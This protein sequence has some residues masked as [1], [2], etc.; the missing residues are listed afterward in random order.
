MSCSL[1]SY[2]NLLKP[3]TH[4]T[5]ATGQEALFA[6]Q[7]IVEGEGAR[8]SQRHDCHPPR[9]R[10]ITVNMHLV[11]RALGI[12]PATGHPL[13]LGAKS[14]DLRLSDNAFARRLAT[15][16]RE[17]LLRAGGAVHID[18][19][20]ASIEQRPHQLT[21]RVV[22]QSTRQS[23]ARDTLVT[24]P[25]LRVRPCKDIESQVC[26]ILN[27]DRFPSKCCRICRQ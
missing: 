14:Q 20:H 3:P 23:T 18:S 12:L 27:I 17:W 15:T 5:P 21:Q 1:I 26:K 22:C 2:V 19:R 9:T 13:A 24:R 10:P 6:T 25:Y 11:S 8:G 16:K 4:Y 7:R